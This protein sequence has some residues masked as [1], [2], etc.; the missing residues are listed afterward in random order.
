MQ[1]TEMLC[2]DLSDEEIY[3]A[4]L[5]YSLLHGLERDPE[6]LRQLVNSYKYHNRPDEIIDDAILAYVEDSLRAP[7]DIVLEVLGSSRFYELELSG[8]LLHRHRICEPWFENGCRFPLD[9]GPNLAHFWTHVQADE[10][11]EQNREKLISGMRLRLEYQASDTVCLSHRD[12]GVL[13]QLP[14]RLASELRSPNLASRS[15][16][17]LVD[18]LPKK[19]AASGDSLSIAILV[20]TAH[21]RVPKEEIVEYSAHAFRALRSKC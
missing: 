1:E 9:G 16:L 8:D 15:F 7:P 13:G 10:T 4:F 5:L 14:S 6:T 21:E 12:F 18:R 17:P 19:T 11:A 20:T 3:Q 2:D